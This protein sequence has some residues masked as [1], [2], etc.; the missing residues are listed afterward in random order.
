MRIEIFLLYFC[1]SHNSETTAVKYREQHRSEK[2]RS[3][4][5]DIE[6]D[7]IDVDFTDR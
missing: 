4:A 7:Q 6:F 2:L 1:Q 5:L 3:R